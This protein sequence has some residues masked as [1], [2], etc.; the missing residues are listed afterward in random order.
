MIGHARRTGVSVLPFPSVLSALAK[1]GTI[2]LVRADD[3]ASSAAHAESNAVPA[4][5]MNAKR[6]AIRSL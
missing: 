1:P 6:I 3:V 4:T 2:E 5:S